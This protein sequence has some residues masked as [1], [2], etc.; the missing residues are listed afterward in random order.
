MDERTCGPGDKRT[1]ACFREEGS[2]VNFTSPWIDCEMYRRVTYMVGHEVK[3][4]IIDGEP[5]VTGYD[6][7]PT[8]T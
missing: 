6:G 8:L 5:T 1:L 7:R 4:E 3:V 2:G